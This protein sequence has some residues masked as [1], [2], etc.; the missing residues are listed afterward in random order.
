MIA[1]LVSGGV[2]GFISGLTGV[3]GGIFL[4]PVLLILNWAG[5]RKTSAV[6]AVFILVNSVSGLAG[7]IRKGGALPDHLAWWSVAVITGGFIGSSLGATKFNSPVLRVLLGV[8]LFMAGM[9][10]V[11]I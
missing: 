7:F 6:A 3:G 1:S 9:K 5:L 8:V 10:L 11:V 4:S 2:I